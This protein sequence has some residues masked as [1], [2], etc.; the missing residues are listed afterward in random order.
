MVTIPRLAQTFLKCKEK[1]NGFALVWTI[2][3][4]FTM[5]RADLPFPGHLCNSGS[6]ARIGLKCPN[7]IFFYFQP[8]FLSL[9]FSI[10]HQASWD[11]HSSWSCIEWWSGVRWE[12]DIF[13]Y[14]CYYLHTLK[15]LV[16]PV[17]RICKPQ[18]PGQH[19]EGQGR[20]GAMTYYRTGD[21]GQALSRTM[22]QE[23]MYNRNQRQPKG[24]YL[25]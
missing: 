5:G 22:N 4:Q 6:L 25:P 20:A 17:F 15:Y 2:F 16:P 9:F 7:K 8:F 23:L 18:F 10:I 24:K 1:K 11:F 21:R 13:L 19:G 14:Q 3:W 12:V